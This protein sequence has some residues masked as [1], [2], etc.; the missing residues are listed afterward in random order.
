M[1]NQ[2]ELLCKLSSFTI[3]QANKENIISRLDE[4]KI[5]MEE[6]IIDSYRKMGSLRVLRAILR[7]KEFLSN[8]EI[9]KSKDREIQNLLESFI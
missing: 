4:I 6:N 3:N 5:S 2:R 8:G 7:Y 9:L 1:L